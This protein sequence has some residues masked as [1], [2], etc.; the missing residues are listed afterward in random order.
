MSPVTPATSVAATDETT[1]VPE[2]E[3][4]ESQGDPD[5]MVD[6]AL[7]QLQSG[8][9]PPM[10]GILKI[11]EVAEKYPGN[12]KANFTLGMLSMQTGQY[13]K[14]VGRFETVIEQQPEN[15]DAWYL[16]TKSQL[17]IGD[18]INAKQS[19]EK[20]LT[21][22]DEETGNEYKKELPELE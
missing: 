9:V 19:F 3:T 20:T 6:E 11:R 7:R 4:S 5:A 18:T 2:E 12:V 15:A 14:A 21:L 16:L 17:N 13:A 10:Q 1:A 8:E 22:V